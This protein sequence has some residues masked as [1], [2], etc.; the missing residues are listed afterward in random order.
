MIRTPLLVLLATAP[1]ICLAQQRLVLD[2]DSHHF[3]QIRAGIKVAHRFRIT[4]AGD[5]PLRIVRVNPSCG[6]T[7]TVVG[8]QVLEPG[9]ATELEAVFDATGYR[10]PVKKLIE[11]V[12]DDPA[13][14]SRTLA[15]EADVLAEVI[16]ETQEVA[17]RDLARKDRRKRSVK[18]TSGTG[19]PIAVLD[20]ELSEAPWL[21]VATR[22]AGKDVFVDLVLLARNLPP[23]RESGTDT[24]AFRVANPNPSVVNLRVSW[25]KLAPVIA[26]PARVALAEPAGREIPCTVTLRSR[27]GKPFRI[28]SA[29]STHPLIQVPDLPSA[30]PRQKLRFVVAGTLPAGSWDEQVVLAL[31][32]GRELTIRFSMVIR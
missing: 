21:G 13:G 17:F 12:S 18:L 20:A 27:D 22:P 14:P 16:P 6:C 23:G 29:R 9:E 31:E 3:G 10:G 1:V 8:K 25:E 30:A 26:E 5:A 19:E 4:N 15:V 32:G 28:L 11:L 24:L 7:S 2:A